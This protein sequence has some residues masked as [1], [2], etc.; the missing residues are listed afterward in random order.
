MGKA[1]DLDELDS[2]WNALLS[3]LDDRLI[4][5]VGGPVPFS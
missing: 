5:L 4:M 3:E 1:Y 2:E